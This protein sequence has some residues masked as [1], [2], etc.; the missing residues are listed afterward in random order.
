MAQKK[1]IS[2]LADRARLLLWALP[3]SAVVRRWIYAAIMTQSIVL[4]KTQTMQT[5][6]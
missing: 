3:G 2:S 1:L 4:D 5:L 6:Y